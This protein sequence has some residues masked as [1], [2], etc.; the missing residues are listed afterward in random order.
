M[1]KILISITLVLLVAGSVFAQSQAEISR[2]AKNGSKVIKGILTKHDLE[3]DTAFAWYAENL[4]SYHPH[5]TAV[6]A[7]RKNPNIEFIVFM[8]TWCDDSHFIIPKFFSLLDSSG[9]SQE[10]V[11]MFGC[12]RNKKTLHHFSEALNITNVP[13]I[14]VMSKGKEMGRVIEYGKTGYWDKEIGEIISAIPV[15]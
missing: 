12:D 14:I 13:T 3:S 1:K 6:A 7:L 10:K 8:G 5:P 11:S 9:I 2:D 15:E 4:R